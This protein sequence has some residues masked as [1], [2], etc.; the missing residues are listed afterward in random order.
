MARLT[1]LLQKYQSEFHPVIPFRDGTDRLMPLDFSEANEDLTEEIVKDT[2]LFTQYI[3]RQLKEG[4]S[5][6]GIG[7]YK[8]HRTVYSRSAVFDNKEE[9]EPRRFHLGVDVWG[10]IYTPV[11]A[12]LDG[13]VHSFAFNNAYGDYGVA[14]ILTHRLDEIPFYTLYGHLSLNDIKNLREGQHIYKGDVIGEFGIAVENGHWPPHLHFQVIGDMEGYKGDY[15][16][17]CAYSKREKY[18]DNC[19]DPDLILQLERFLI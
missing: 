6:Y 17:V 8:E 4:N 5:R 1:S 13:I 18:I 3:N 15:P 19:P 10:K 7:G 11:Y 9:E 14:I 16:G 12:P 2:T